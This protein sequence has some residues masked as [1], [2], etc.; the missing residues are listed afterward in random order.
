ESKTCSMECREK[1]H[2]ASLPARQCGNC[3]KP[4]KP[5]KHHARYCSLECNIEA[6]AKKGKAE[7]A[8]RL[9]PRPCLE[10]GEVFE[11]R[12]MRNLLCSKMCKDR[13]YHRL[14]AEEKAAS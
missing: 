6:Q 4:F 13:R 11:P 3:A 9:E 1:L 10:C 12:T 5:G 8:A 7:R 14:K 2:R